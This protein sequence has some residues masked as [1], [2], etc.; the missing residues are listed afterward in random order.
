LLPDRHDSGRDVLLEADRAEQLIEREMQSLTLAEAERRLGVSANVMKILLDGG[1][2][3]MVDSS[4]VA[5]SVK[6][7]MVSDSGRTNLTGSL[8]GFSKAPSRSMARS[9]RL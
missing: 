5:G 7:P 6:V 2:I 1:F 8:P 4:N 3:S 9:R